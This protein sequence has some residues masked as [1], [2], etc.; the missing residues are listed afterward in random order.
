[1]KANSLPIKEEQVIPKF[2]EEEFSDV[3]T[4]E[5]P[6]GLLPERPITHTITLIPGKPPPH[7]APYRLTWEEK[8]ELEVQISELLEKGF[9]VPQASPY[10]A[11]LF[12]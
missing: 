4:D 10:G 9:I 6:R 1:M 2:I 11:P 3:V 7:K 8:Q 12:L 5:L